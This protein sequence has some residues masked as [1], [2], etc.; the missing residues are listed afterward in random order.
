MPCRAAQAGRPGLTGYEAWFRAPGEKEIL[1]IS[2]EVQLAIKEGRSAGMTLD[3]T[4]KR[5]VEMHLAVPESKTLKKYYASPPDADPAVPAPKEKAFDHEPFRTVIIEIVRSNKDPCVSSIYDVLVERFVDSGEYDSLPASERSLRRFVAFLKKNGIVQQTQKCGRIYDHVF[6][7]PP[8]EQML[9]DFG[10]YAPANGPHLHFICLLLRY[11]RFL[12]VFAQDH[13]YNSADACRAI[14]SAFVKLGGRPSQLVIDQDAVF[15]HTETYGE[16]IKTNV[17]ERFCQEQQLELFVCRKADPESKGPIENSVGYVKKN[18]LSARHE[19]STEEL[20]SGLP[21]WLHRANSRIHRA[22]FC[23]PEEVFRE[24]EKPV[25]GPLLP[26]LYNNSPR[27]YTQVDLTNYPYIQY[28][29]NKYYYPHEYA[30]HTVLYR[31]VDGIIY[32]Y[33]DR[34][35]LVATYPVSPLK[36]KSFQKEEFAHKPTEWLKTVEKLRRRWDCR[37]FEHF[38]NGIKKEA[39]GRYLDERFEAIYQYF[40]AKDLDRKSAA[41]LMAYCCDNWRY[42]PSQVRDSWELLQKSPGLV[43]YPD[44]GQTPHAESRSLD[45]YQKVFDQLAGKGGDIT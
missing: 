31:V 27:S 15:I 25:L 34:R 45:V 23:V 13:K 43:G 35:V 3:E 14:Y 5:L 4:E 21:A 9:I 18:Y 16:V 41:K 38:V 1:L 33:S 39:K 36:G 44:Q 7:T 30:F 11:S 6:D 37:D 17:F 40:D 29:S 22:T 32:L 20:I 10:D 12:I 24:F 2:K 26:S 19:R 8:G 42:T 28:K